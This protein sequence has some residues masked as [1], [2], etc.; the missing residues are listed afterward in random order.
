MSSSFSIMSI[1]L[2]FVD[3]CELRIQ[4]STFTAFDGKHFCS[5]YVITT[6]SDTRNAYIEAKL[7]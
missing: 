7:I 6:N 3:N 4:S 2:S 1:S 5:N